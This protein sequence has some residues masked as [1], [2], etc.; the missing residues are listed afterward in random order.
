D[1]RFADNPFVTGDPY[2]VFYAGVPLITENGFALGSLCVVHD[3]PT[4]LSDSQLKSLKALSKQAM[5]LIE[6]R[7]KKTQLER[8][9]DRLNEKNKSL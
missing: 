9:T 8:V 5:R 3:Q 1:E 2:V 4:Q 7:R 6:L